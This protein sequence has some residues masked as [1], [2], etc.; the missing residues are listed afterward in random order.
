[1]SYVSDADFAVD[2][3]KMLVAAVG[4]VTVVGGFVTDDGYRFPP[5]TCH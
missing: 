2:S 1:M 5:T 3:E 4:V